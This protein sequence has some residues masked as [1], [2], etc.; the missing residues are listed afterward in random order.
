MTNDNKLI[1]NGEYH[2][3]L[4]LVGHYKEIKELIEELKK[5]QVPKIYVANS[6]RINIKDQYNRD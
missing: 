2:Q 3:H 6:K 1:L 5:K 4:T